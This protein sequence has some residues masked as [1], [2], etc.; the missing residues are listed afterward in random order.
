MECIQKVLNSPTRLSRQ[1]ASELVDL[2]QPQPPHVR[3]KVISEAPEHASSLLQQQLYDD[4]LESWVGRL[5]KTAR[6]EVS[7]FTE[8]LERGGDPRRFHTH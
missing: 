8:R 6:R 2:L 1:A 7:N 5:Q 3:D 4:Q